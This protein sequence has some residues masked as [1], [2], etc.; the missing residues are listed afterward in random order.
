MINQLYK[1]TYIWKTLLKNGKILIYKFNSNLKY[2][3]PKED[4]K[5]SS[6]WKDLLEQQNYISEF[7][8]NK[9]R[10]GRIWCYVDYLDKH[11]NRCQVKVYKDEFVSLKIYNK[12]K[13]FEL[14]FFRM[15]YL[16]E[17]LNADEFIKL[18]RDNEVKYIGNL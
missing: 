9:D 6:K 17:Q 14:S 4:F 10:K 2:G 18:L 15:H 12:V 3:E 1:D 11:Y 13:I 16:V 5:E 8:G 7:E